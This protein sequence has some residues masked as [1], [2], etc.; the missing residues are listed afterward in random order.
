MGTSTPEAHAAW[1][2]KRKE[3]RKHFKA[4]VLADSGI[5]Q[6]AFIAKLATV[7]LTSDASTRNSS[8]SKTS[9]NDLDSADIAKRYE[10]KPEQL[11]TV[12]ERIDKNKCR[13][14]G[15]SSYKHPEYQR[16][17]EDDTTCVNSWAREL[18][19]TEPKA[20]RPKPNGPMKS[21]GAKHNSLTRIG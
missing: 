14:R 17:D 15:V 2:K 16:D 18:E 10:G 5:S 7:T 19:V 9:V 8:S 12:C 6:E 20:K 21:L 1:Q 13:I 4:I 3:E 11:Q